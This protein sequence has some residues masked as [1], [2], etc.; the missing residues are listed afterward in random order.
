[1]AELEERVEQLEKLV[2]VLQRQNEALKDVV[3]GDYP[4]SAFDPN[5]GLLTRVENLEMGEVD[6]QELLS[7]DGSGDQLPIQRRTQERRMG[8]FKET[9]NQK[10]LYRATYVWEVFTEQAIHDSGYFK[11]KSKQVQRILENA[12]GEDF[13]TDRTTVGR[14]M[15][16]VAKHTD[17]D[18]ECT[19]PTAESCLITMHKSRSGT[20][21][22]RA[23]REQWQSYFDEQIEE[24]VEEDI[25][26]IRATAET[27][28]DQIISA[29][30]SHD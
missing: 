10:N 9:G 7:T 26:E 18:G 3:F 15:D 28:M 23:D 25:D 5:Q 12:E 30:V 6:V 24:S 27:E 2:N 16:T 1:M 17:I 8:Q 14:V 4:M 20:T 19:D 21:V 29:E 11:L 22:L 13:P